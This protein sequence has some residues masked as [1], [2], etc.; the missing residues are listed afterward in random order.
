MIPT[1]SGLY[2]AKF[3]K[4][5]LKDNY[6]IVWVDSMRTGIFY[7]L[8][9]GD[10]VA[11]SI[12]DFTNWIG[13][14]KPPISLEEIEASATGRITLWKCDRCHQFIVVPVVAEKN[15]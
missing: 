6:D 15:E 13:P 2:W 11:Y 4:D 8:R 14:L 9:L 5:N 10:E 1:E 3:I 12:K 7:V